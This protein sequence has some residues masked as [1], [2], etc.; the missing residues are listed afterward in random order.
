MRPG[1]L[2][3][4]RNIGCSNSALPC[5]VVKNGQTTPKESHMDNSMQEAA[6]AISEL[7][8]R[9]IDQ[10]LAALVPMA[11]TVVL[12]ASGMRLTGVCFKR[13]GT[14]N[15]HGAHK[16]KGPH[17]FLIVAIVGIMLATHFVEVA[18]WAVFYWATNMLPDAVTAMF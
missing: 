8:Y 17:L 16:D 15:G 14:R 11:V 6:Q 18:A 12:H 1:R 13:F 7:N 10:F 5:S 2:L 9:Y 4:C 3:L